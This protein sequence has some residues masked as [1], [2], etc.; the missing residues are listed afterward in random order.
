MNHSTVDL[1]CLSAA[2]VES[3]M[4]EYLRDPSRVPEAWRGYFAQLEFR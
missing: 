4:E 1:D 2:Y 3:L